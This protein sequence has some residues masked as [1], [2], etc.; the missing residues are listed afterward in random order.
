MVKTRILNSFASEKNALIDI[1]NRKI[2]ATK[3]TA[4]NAVF[5]NKY[6]VALDPVTELLNAI[7][8]KFRKCETIYYLY[9]E[10]IDHNIL[11]G[12]TSSL[13]YEMDC[14]FT[15][16]ASTLRHYYTIDNKA[17]Y[18]E[19][20]DL[21]FQGFILTLASIYENLVLLAEI[22]IKKVMIYIK[23]PLSA[24]LQDYLLYLKRLVDLGYRK[25]DK[26]NICMNTFDP[27]FTKYLDQINKLRNKFIHGFSLNVHSDGYNYFVD[28]MDKTTFSTTSPDLIIDQ[29]TKHVL[30]NTRNFIRE[31]L[32]ALKES[33]RHHRKVIPA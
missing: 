2:A 19:M 9:F 6:I 16:P 31:L 11:A 12:N 29:F 27:F 32:T 28:K 15:D 10:N 14:T 4:I 3:F 30:D 25:N 22:F 13:P 24:P 7:D 26:L 5:D 18:K 33:T 20:I 21:N 17:G 8:A 1:L 23:K